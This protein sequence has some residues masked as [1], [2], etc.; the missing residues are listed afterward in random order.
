MKAT[1]FRDPAESNEASAI[2]TPGDHF[3]EA[4][5]PRCAHSVDAVCPVCSFHVEQSG[6][7]SKTATATFSEY[8][9][10]LILL[11]M[12]SRNAKFTLQC[13]LIAT[14][15]AFADGFSMTDFAKRWSVGRATISKHC[16][17]ICEQLEIKPSPYMMAEEMAGKFRLANRRPSKVKV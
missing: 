16:R 12:N 1:E 4:H 15:D 7:S 13:L 14:G 8:H 9:R 11:V 10:R 17:L 6:A 2:D 3:L 5:C